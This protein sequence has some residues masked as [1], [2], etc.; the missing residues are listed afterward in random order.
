M[1]A[2]GVLRGLRRLRAWSSTVAAYCGPSGISELANAR[3]RAQA[4]TGS[5]ILGACLTG[6]V[7]V[8]TA[9]HVK[10]GIPLGP[11][12]IFGASLGAVPPV[13]IAVFL[14]R[15]Y[16][17][18]SDARKVTALARCL[19]HMA[20]LLAGPKR[21]AMSAEWASHLSGETGTG[22]PSRRQARDA[23]GF[24]VSAIRYRCSD[25]ADA[26]WTPVD[27]VLNSRTLS[28]LFVLVPTGATAY[29]VLRHEGTLGVVKAAESIGM[30]GGMLYG[31]IR[32]GRWWRNVKPPEPKA[33]RVKE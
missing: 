33:R 21:A 13:G 27:A 14:W 32:T 31:L 4:S 28:N 9:E 11:P 6:L 23:L 16:R 30:I 20:V 26:A 15:R 8:A 10:V 3:I 17:R 19:T 18:L 24:V 12:A 29:L 25:A 1:R 22:V 2:V 7:A 5:A